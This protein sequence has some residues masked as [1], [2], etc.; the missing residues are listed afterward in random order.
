M[1]KVKQALV[2]QLINGKNRVTKYNYLVTKNDPLSFTTE[3]FQKIVIDLDYLNIDDNHKVLQ[4]TSTI[5]SEGKTTFVSNLA[6][7]LQQKNKKVIL[8]DLDLRRPKINRAFGVPNENGINDYMSG[9]IHLEEAIKHSD[10]I[11]IDYMVTGETTS[12]VTNILESQKLKD[13]IAALREKYDYVLLDTPP[14]IAVSDSIL[15]SKMADGIIFIIAQGKAKKTLVKEAI[16]TLKK[17]DVN[18]IGIVFNQVKMDQAGYGYK[19]N[20]N[21]YSAKK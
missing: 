19:N 18:I 11:G 12:L 15:I 10:E 5:P 13:L 2:D 20:Y 17:Y 7:L 3:S 9:K 1:E 4:F 21:Y 6:Y 16:Q 14:I 8:L